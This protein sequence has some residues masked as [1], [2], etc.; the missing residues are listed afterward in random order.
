VA[1]NFSV[2]TDR[3]REMAD[4]SVDVGAVNDPTNLDSVEERT[5]G[6]QHV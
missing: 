5:R 3:V 4:T 2:V 1:S 6:T